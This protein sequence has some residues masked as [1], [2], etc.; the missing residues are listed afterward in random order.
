VPI[1]SSHSVDSLH[2]APGARPAAF[3]ARVIE[4][5]LRVFLPHRVEGNRLGQVVSQGEVI[6]RRSEW[7][8]NGRR[9]VCASGSFDLLHPGHIRLL[10]QARSYGEFLVVAV[11]DDASVRE[12]F[13]GDRKAVR[14]LTPAPERMEIVA[15]LAAVDFVVPFAGPSLRAF[16]LRLAPDVFI[17]G[18]SA[19]QREFGVHQHDLEALGSRIVHVPLEPGYSTEQLIERIAHLDT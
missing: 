10:E 4:S 14:P 5:G 12:Q 6:L 13:S 11:Q 15:A 3:E 2:L 19:A 17:E 8:R 16:L 18:R 9:V 1:V 7:K